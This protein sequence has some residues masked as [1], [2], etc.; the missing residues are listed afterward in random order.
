MALSE[1]TY[2]RKNRYQSISQD[3]RGGVASM[4]TPYQH[5]GR[6]RMSTYLYET[7]I[8]LFR[9]TLLSHVSLI[10]FVR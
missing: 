5:H 8:V 7:K 6:Y 2:N 1:L 10:L 3:G 4:A 9:H